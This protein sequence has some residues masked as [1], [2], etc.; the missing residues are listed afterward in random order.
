MLP[1]PSLAT[2]TALTILVCNL[3]FM[4]IQHS[5]VFDSEQFEHMYLLRGMNVYPFKNFYE[6]ARS[7]PVELYWPWANI[8][9]KMNG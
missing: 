6:V 4:W 8:N 5:L 3:V 2:N 1:C 7:C 9:K